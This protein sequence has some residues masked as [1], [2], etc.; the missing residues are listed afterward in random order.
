[1]RVYTE[2]VTGE[3][4]DEMVKAGEALVRAA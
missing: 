2:A 3:I 1:V 4:R